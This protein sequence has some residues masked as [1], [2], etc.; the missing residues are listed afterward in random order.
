ME[1]KPKKD[2]LG[3]FSTD[4]EEQLAALPHTVAF[5][6]IMLDYMRE[7]HTRFSTDEGVS[8]ELDTSLLP[9]ELV[10]TFYFPENARVSDM[11]AILDETKDT[12]G[13]LWSL[14][15]RFAINGIVYLLTGNNQAMM[16]QTESSE[17]SV[18]DFTTTHSAAT[19]L[20]ATFITS[21]IEPKAE[22]REQTIG[23]YVG[24]A[25]GTG[26]KNQLMA[27]GN[28]AGSTNC[29]TTAQLPY[30]DGDRMILATYNEVETMDSSG[31]SAHID[32]AWELIDTTST[33]FNLVTHAVRD[34]TN[35]DSHE[36][37]YAEVSSTSA[38]IEDY[39][40]SRELPE[41][42][43]DEEFKRPLT[44]DRND[45]RWKRIAVIFIA[46]LAPLLDE[47]KKFDT[48]ELDE[49]GFDAPDSGA[50]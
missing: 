24:S 2:I 22:L 19:R 26:Y 30:D 37:N 42:F 3:E 43:P 34:R 35:D 14:K 41:L 44:I 28:L 12:E 11:R 21:L 25:D 48:T 1:P 7:R 4:S 8:F 6:Q 29:A 16:V 27:L 50:A 39:L 5:E 15:V 45:P 13:D 20:L 31:I 23:D 36:I 33:E 40:L 9:Q 47:Y 18:L 46:T 49:D 38:P 32:L 10:D 17:G